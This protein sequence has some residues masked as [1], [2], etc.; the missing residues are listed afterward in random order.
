MPDS[1]VTDLIVTRRPGQSLLIRTLNGLIRITRLRRNRLSIQSPKDV[2]ILREELAE[3]GA[4]SQVR[5]VAE[6]EPRSDR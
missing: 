6:T 1:D 2:V 4:D 5:P 3:D